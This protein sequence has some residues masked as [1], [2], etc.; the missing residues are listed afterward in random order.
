MDRLEAGVR[1]KRHPTRH[2]VA[3]VADVHVDQSDTPDRLRPR[4]DDEPLLGH[5]RHVVSRPIPAAFTEQRDLARLL[6]V[7]DDGAAS[8]VLSGEHDL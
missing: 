1:E 3:A 7:D 6:P 8:R 4:A 5:F 2:F